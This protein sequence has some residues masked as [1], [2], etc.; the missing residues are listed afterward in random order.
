MAKWLLI[1][2]YNL[3]FRSFYAVPELS[4]SDGMPTN[5][6]HGWVRTLWRLEDIQ[7]PDRMVVFYDLGGDV[8]REKLYPD[9][10][11]N[12]GE[13]PE[14]LNDQ[15]PWIKK[16]TEA[17]G[18]GRVEKEGVEADDL[19]GASARR[20][21]AEGHIVKMVSADKDLA[22]CVAPG[23]T[24]LLPPPTTNPKLGWRELDEAGVREKFGVLPRQIPDYLA[25][26]GDTSDNIP[27]LQ[28]VGPKTAARWLAQYGDL[29]GIILNCG[30]LKPTRFQ[31][32]V[33]K[34]QETIRLNLLLTTLDHGDA[35]ISLEPQQP[36]PAKLLSLLESLEM[37]AAR[38]AA[39]Q[40]YKYP[41]G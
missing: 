8:R 41:A 37:K 28:G 3:A 31:N 35:E 9:Y 10:K 30:Q 22:Q 16:L 6:I 21:T 1:D 20:L 7:Q 27:G 38:H 36:D 39:A 5:A 23:S 33:H 14:A 26:M 12:R 24:Q 13:C 11:A 40:R 29:E 25:L 4:R 15:I 32:L 34:N 2:G 17:M 19:I 18:Y